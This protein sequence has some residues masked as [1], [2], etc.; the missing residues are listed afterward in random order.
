MLAKQLKAPYRNYGRQYLGI[1]VEGKQLLQ[2]RGF[3]WSYYHHDR[4]RSWE[5]TPVSLLDS[6][7]CVFQLNYDPA[8]RT[9]GEI[10]WGTP[11]A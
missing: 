5:R 1:T 6:G 10:E 7:A 3:C 4:S 9:L 8:S 11:G 2:V